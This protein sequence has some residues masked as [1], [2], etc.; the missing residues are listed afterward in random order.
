VIKIFYEL[1]PY[2][3]FDLLKTIKTGSSINNEEKHNTWKATGVEKGCSLFL[4]VLILK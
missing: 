4:L 1:L 2:R 3:L